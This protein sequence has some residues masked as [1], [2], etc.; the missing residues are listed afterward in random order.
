MRRSTGV[1]RT[2]I[3]SDIDYYPALLFA[4]KFA[5]LLVQPT[6]ESTPL[7]DQTGL[8]TTVSEDTQGS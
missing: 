3:A 2:R 1:A 8:R 4:L 5:P 7:C 6:T